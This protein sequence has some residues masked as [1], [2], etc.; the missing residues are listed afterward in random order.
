MAII[1]EKQGVWTPG[2]RRTVAVCSLVFAIGTALQNFVIIDPRMIELAMRLA[3]RTPAEAAAEAPG[4]LT[5]LRLVGNLYLAGNLLGLLA[6][7]PRA[8]I[9][10]V[11]LVV[12]VTQA[13]GVFAIPPAVFGASLEL[14][15][16]AGL[17]PSL[18]TDGGALV[19]SIVLLVRWV[20]GRKAT[21]SVPGDQGSTCR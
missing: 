18:L 7:W 12:N 14:Y 1:R 15:G 17:L 16:P 9:F 19:L 8:R 4:F 5:T 10:W 20:S 21:R 6:L 11:T 2:L 13:A 3:G